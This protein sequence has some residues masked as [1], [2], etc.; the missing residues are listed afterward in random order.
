MKA[1]WTQLKAAGKAL[2]KEGVALKDDFKKAIKAAIFG[3]R[4]ARRKVAA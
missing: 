4:K 2:R 3:G 1:K